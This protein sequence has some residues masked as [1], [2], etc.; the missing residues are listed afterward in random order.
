M[1]AITD[2]STASSVASTDFFVV[3]QSGTDK[4]AQLLGLAATWNG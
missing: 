2:L 3:S 1:A 4:K